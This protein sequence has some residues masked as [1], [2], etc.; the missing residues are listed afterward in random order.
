MPTGVNAPVLPTLISISRSLVSFSS[1]G[2][3]YASAHLGNLA[4]APNNS[5]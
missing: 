3:L 4:V 5:L 2:Y 1:G